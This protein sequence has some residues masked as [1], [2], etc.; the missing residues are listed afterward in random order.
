M[1][2]TQ[3]FLKTVGSYKNTS[4]AFWL[5]R[6]ELMFIQWSQSLLENL[7]V[8]DTVDIVADTVDIVAGRH[9]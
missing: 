2:I 3:T 1:K 8:A 4:V 7:F 5:K 9:K 6:A